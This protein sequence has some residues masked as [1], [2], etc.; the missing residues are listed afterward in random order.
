MAFLRLGLMTGDEGLYAIGTGALRANHLWLER[1]PQACPSLFLAMQLH[2]GDPREVV[3]AGPED[4]AKSA[5]M[6]AVLRAEFPWHRVVLRVHS[7]NRAALAELSGLV[8]GKEP[9]AGKAA[10][11]V[12]RRGVCE[13]PVLEA[14][15]LTTR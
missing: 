6:V 13:A 1:A 7:A 8:A 15:A 11:Y 9:V 4:D 3:I 2:L 14:E 12:C 5:A 10:A